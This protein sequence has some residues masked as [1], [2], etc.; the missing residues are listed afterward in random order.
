[1]NDTTGWGHYGAYAIAKTIRGVL[2]E[3][4]AGDTGYDLFRTQHSY[5]IKIS[6][7]DRITDAKRAAHEHSRIKE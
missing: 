4:E 3:I 2:Y 6:N 5:R 7:H 1:M